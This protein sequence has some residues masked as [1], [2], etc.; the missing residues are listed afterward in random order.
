MI[1]KIKREAWD[2][3]PAIAS[4]TDPGV[5]SFLLLH[6]QLDIALSLAFI[7]VFAGIII[8]LELIVSPLIH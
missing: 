6:A 2:K 7:L 3:A 4:T 8:D 1:G 5:G